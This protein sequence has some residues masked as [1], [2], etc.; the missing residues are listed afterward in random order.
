VEGVEI[1]VGSAHND[2]IVGV[3]FL[4][5]TYY[6]GNGNDFLS[7]NGEGGTPGDGGQDSA[8]DIYYG[9]QGI[10]ATGYSGGSGSV[11]IDLSTGLG[12]GGNAQNDRYFSIEHVIGSFE[13]DTLTGSNRA[14]T[15]D[16]FD[17]NDTLFGGLE[18]DWVIG[19][20]GND[21]A[22]GGAGNDRVMGGDGDDLVLGING[23]SDFIDG[24]GGDDIIDDTLGADTIFGGAGNDTV[25]YSSSSYQLSGGSGIDTLLGTAGA[26][27]I[28][29]GVA[30]FSASGGGSAATANTN[31]GAF[32]LIDLGDGNDLLYFTTASAND[33]SLTVF[34][35][36][37]NDQLSMLD[38]DAAIGSSH[39]LYGGDGSDKIW[40]GWFGMGGNATVFGGAG[41]DIIYSGGG[42][43]VESGFDDTLY[44]GDGFD[45]YYWSP[46]SG[47]FGKDI[48]F[49]SSAGGN[50]LVIFSGNTAPAAGFPDTGAVDNDP[51]N[52]K[53]SLV[54]LGG[55]WF[56]IQ[57]KDD[58][59]SAIRFRGG[60]ITVINLHSR[61]GGGMPGE[62]FVYTWD[63]AN[64]VWID[65][66]G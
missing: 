15:L 7:G 25:Q 31:A 54:D 57:D 44:G 30:R 60:D 4:S 55:G 28:D 18:D 16:G 32:D 59:S 33:L 56:Q 12:F 20:G 22:V 26:D 29:L 49:D 24:E 38:G 3:A 39:A 61:P 48:I 41:D 6:G 35:G 64:N 65:Q 47:G 62:N 53:V 63:A 14:D 43:A 46:N 5:E 17:A 8:G 40:A 37:G 11:T 52:G 13:N 66:N 51:I 9:G 23:G 21:T 42:T 19:G 27:T 10:D 36:A 34:G 45:L 1:Y 50:G 58:P 2:H